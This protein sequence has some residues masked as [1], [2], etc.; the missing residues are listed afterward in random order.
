MLHQLQ[1]T[2]KLQLNISFGSSSVL[3]FPSHTNSVLELTTYCKLYYSSQ[4][5]MR[6]NPGLPTATAVQQEFQQ[7]TSQV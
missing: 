7:I 3:F 6:T 4:D 2:T 5:I 1:V